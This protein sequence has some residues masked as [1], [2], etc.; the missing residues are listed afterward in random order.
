MSGGGGG[1]G[2]GSVVRRVVR[3]ETQYKPLRAEQNEEK[4][5]LLSKMEALYADACGR[6]GAVHGRFVTVARLVDA[7][8]CIGLLD[9][10]SNIVANTLATTD[11]SP[12]TTCPF[13]LHSLE[14]QLPDLGRRSLD[15]LTGFL[16]SSS[17]TSPPGRPSATCS[18]PTPTSSSPRAS[19]WRT[20]PWSISQSPPPHRAFEE[21][22]TLAARMAGHPDPHRLL[23]LWASLSTRLPEAL[24]KMSELQ[25]F[26]RRQTIVYQF[27]DWLLQKSP[28]AA[29]AACGDPPPPP[30]VVVV[31]LAQSWDIAAS[32]PGCSGSRITNTMF[33]YQHI[34]CLKM[35]L[36]NTIHGFY[37]RALARLPRREL[38]HRF[39][40]SLPKAGSCYGPMDPVSNIEPMYQLHII[41]GL[42][43]FV[44][45]P[46]YCHDKDDALSVSPCKYR[47]THVNFLVTRKD[48]LSAGKRPILF[49]AEFDNEEEEVAPL[50][51]CCVDAPTPFAEHVRCLY[52]EAQGAKIVHPCLEK[53]HGGDE[54]FEEV[55]RGKR[56]F[57]NARLICKSEFFVQRLGGNEEDFMYVNTRQIT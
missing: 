36:L 57:T 18:A 55:I 53:F 2:E 54:D 34:R 24:N 52:C 51:C 33:S 38:R 35:V 20:A 27:R 15:G 25:G 19:S 49:F 11:L 31:D 56:Y 9:P 32:R 6:V 30:A 17:P 46:E 7:G 23:R 42:N 21:A 14:D 47:Y 44:C 26:H 10:V 3:P 22:L 5:R 41:C 8:V 39:H 28:A 12:D 13:P 29:A 45:G 43:E 37:L 48:F 16:L 4:A 40:R 50:L 1:V